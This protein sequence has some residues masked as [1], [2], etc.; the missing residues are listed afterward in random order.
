MYPQSRQVQQSRWWAAAIA[1]VATSRGNL[2]HSRKAYHT[3]QPVGAAAPEPIP[4]MNGVIESGLR[5]STNATRRA[6]LVSRAL[7]GLFALLPRGNQS[8][9]RAMNGRP[10][11]FT[12][13]GVRGNQSLRCVPDYFVLGQTKCGTTD[14]YAKIA[15]HPEVYEG[16][17]AHKE[18][19]FFSREWYSG[20]N[21]I[22]G[23]NKAAAIVASGQTRLLIGDGT[24]DHCKPLVLGHAQRITTALR[25][26]NR[27]A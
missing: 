6:S 17:A 14:L 20:E 24:P 3:Q 10:S 4:K 2:N 12:V 11:C 27:V 23:F 25:E 1:E 9:S 5:K 15:R 7:P 19:H 26:L 21:Y 16:P 22:A 8:H 18:R 13:G